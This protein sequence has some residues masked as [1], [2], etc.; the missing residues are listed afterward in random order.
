M[1]LDKVIPWGILMTVAMGL[2]GFVHGV[3]T[4][5]SLNKSH[6]IEQDRLIEENHNRAKKIFNRLNAMEEKLHKGQQEIYKELLH[7]K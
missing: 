3:S 4:D 5:V 1:K 7:R 2:M 6:N